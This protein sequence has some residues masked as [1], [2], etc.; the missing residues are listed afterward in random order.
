MV[1]PEKVAYLREFFSAV[2]IREIWKSLGDSQRDFATDPLQITSH[3]E[4]GESSA[5]VMVT[6]S[7]QASVW[8]AS[9]RE[10]YRLASGGAGVD[11]D[12]LGRGTDWSR[13]MVRA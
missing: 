3:S 13:R 4:A 8:M 10:A 7:E 11:P 9:A 1:D 5:A 2:E 6:T 12:A